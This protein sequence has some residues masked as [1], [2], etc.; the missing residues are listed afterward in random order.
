[1]RSA[2]YGF[3]ISKQLV[4]EINLVAQSVGLSIDLV[5]QMA[6]QEYVMPMLLFVSQK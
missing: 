6:T 2:I 4:D 3:W 1:M 5:G